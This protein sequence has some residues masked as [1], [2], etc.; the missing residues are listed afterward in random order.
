VQFLHYRPNRPREF[1]GLPNGQAILEN[2]VLELGVQVVAVDP[3][4]FLPWNDMTLRI[5][6]GILKPLRKLSCLLVQVLVVHHFAADG[7]RG[8]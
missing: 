8:H 1:L 2:T 6:M 5:M 3:V 7:M 4:R